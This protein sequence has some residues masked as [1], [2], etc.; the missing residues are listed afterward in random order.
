M[1]DFFF[2]KGGL[3]LICLFFF[4]ALSFRVKDCLNNKRNFITSLVLNFIVLFLNLV[5][6]GVLF[7][8]FGYFGGYLKSSF[9]TPLYLQ[10]F[11]IVFCVIVGLYIFSKFYLFLNKF[12]LNYLDKGI[13][14]FKRKSGKI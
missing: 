12:Y 8:S 13:F 5:V 1:L 9:M 3:I 2:D 4:G 7:Y 14:S 10:Y 11:Y 6:I